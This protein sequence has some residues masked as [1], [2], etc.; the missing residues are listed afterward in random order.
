ME[1][2]QIRYFLALSE[3]LNFSRAAERCGVSQPS[4]TRAIKRLE[5]ELGAQLI[6]RERNRT[7][8]TELGRRIKPRL[9]QALS[10]TEIAR[11]DAEDF[12]R[13]S[14]ASLAVG[15]MCTVGPTRMISLVEHLVNEF[16]QM[17]LTLR[18]A[19]GKEMIESLLEGK[20]DVAIVGL[21]EYPDEIAVHD[22]YKERYMI[23]FPSN[24]RF[25]HMDVIPHK[26]MSGE[27]YVLRLNCEYLD[28]FHTTKESYESNEFMKLQNSLRSMNVSHQSEHEEWIQAMVVAG[29]GCAIVPEFMSINTELQMRPLVDPQVMRTIGVA[30][31]RGR[32]HT[33]IVSYFTR[34]CQQMNWGSDVIRPDGSL[35][36]ST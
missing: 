25:M 14:N 36:V 26:E 29:M 27:K 18:T 28:L 30:T 31:V 6:R 22:L 8:L 7:H 17:K 11:N 12:S 32:E 21:A 16:P 5:E 19:S 10:L 34:L 9:E 33:P 15:V 3:D 24:H 23:A 20:I 4:L 13:M 2:Q 35:P 1:L